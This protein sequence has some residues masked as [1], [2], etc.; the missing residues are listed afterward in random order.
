MSGTRTN[1]ENLET[2]DGKTYT[3]DVIETQ[4]TATELA[5]AV[6]NY[7]ESDHGVFLTH[8]EKVAFTWSYSGGPGELFDIKLSAIHEG[9]RS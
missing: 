2:E 5:A 6:M 3:V 9:T 4:L 8:T 1:P 7:L